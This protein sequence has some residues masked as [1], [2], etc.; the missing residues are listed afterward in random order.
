MSKPSTKIL[1]HI[2]HLTPP[3]T[4]EKTAQQFRDLG[5][6]VVPGGTHTGGLAENCLV[7]FQDGVYLELFSFTHPLSH[8]P[9]SSPER[10]K[11]DG[12]GVEYLPDMKGGRERPDGKVLEWVILGPGPELKRGTVLFFC[13]DVTLR[14][15]RVP[16]DPPSNTWHPSTTSGIAH[17]RVLVDEK[18]IVT[19]LNQ[20]TSIINSQP[21][22]AT[23][24]ETAWVLN[25]LSTLSSTSG[26]KSLQLIVST[27]KQDDKHKVLKER[28]PGV[29]EVG[30]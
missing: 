26:Y 20:L 11:Q 8:Y 10:E 3:G 12:S 2:V 23:E 9:P 28:G 13:G 17:V 21:I 16:F 5:F 29:Y 14:H 24:T 7:V 19:L 4:V 27:L 1:D 25:T 15:W 18:D 22:T 6:I 30:L